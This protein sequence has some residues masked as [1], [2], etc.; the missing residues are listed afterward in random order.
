MAISSRVR[1]ILAL[2]AGY[3]AWV[4]AFWIPIFIASLMWSTLSEVGQQFWQEQRY[5]IFPTSTLVFFQ[6]VWLFANAAAGFVAQWVGRSRLPIWIGIGLL[7]GY[8]AYNHWWALWGVMPDWY[9]VLVVI[10]VAPLV[11][12]GSFLAR[13]WTHPWPERRATGP[14]RP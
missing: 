1:D 8:F 7:L 5:D 4:F 3:V 6:F 10:P 14:A 13:R 9:N 12:F 11:W 2:P